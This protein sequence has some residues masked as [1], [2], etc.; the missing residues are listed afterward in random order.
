MKQ[1]IATA[2]VLILL[3][4]TLRTVRADTF[5]L[6]N[7]GQVEGTL[8]NTTE[9][10]RT[11]YVIKTSTGGQITLARDQVAE[12][13]RT[14]STEIEYI[15]HRPDYPDTVEGQMALA[16]LCRTMQ[17][18]EQ[19]VRHLERVIELDPDN[20]KARR[21][22]GYQQVNGEWK[23][24]EEVFQERGM[25]KDDSGHYRVPQQ[26]EEIKR[27]RDQEKARKEW[28]KKVNMWRRWIDSE[29]NQEALAQFQKLNDPMAV[30]ALQKELRDETNETIRKMYIETLARIGSPDAWQTLIIFS[31][32]DADEE[33]RM[34]C[35][36]Y[37]EKQTGTVAVTTYIRRLKSKEN[38]MINRAADALGRMKDKSAV[39]PLIDSL[40]TLHSVQ[41]APPS[42]N[43]NPTFGG[44]GGN[45]GGTFSFGGGGPKTE[46][47]NFNN[48]NVRNALASL[49]GQDFGY[50]QQA[51]KRWLA[52]QKRTPMVDARRERE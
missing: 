48:Q 45:G 2:V 13:R 15:K 49:T 17:L 39:R 33:I 41:V 10:P 36:D 46:D 1:Q 50:D 12:M 44:G 19:R 25:V 31:L 7:G 4:S 21:A 38:Y 52:S 28:F 8:Q 3:P 9:N 23:T 34:T 27:K 29:R 14:K 40:V 6:E 42:G 24:Q 43:M 30:P 37:L 35:L 16:E 20:A 11:S 51:W 26:I 22:L 47:R 32:D 18:P 5:V